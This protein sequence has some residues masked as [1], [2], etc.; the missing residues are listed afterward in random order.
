MLDEVV[1][2]VLYFDAPAVAKY[3]FLVAAGFSLKELYENVFP[4]F[5]RYYYNFKHSKMLKKK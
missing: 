5:L 3:F 1:S 4:C 2:G